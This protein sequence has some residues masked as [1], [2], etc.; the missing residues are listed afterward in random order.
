PASSMSAVAVQ[1]PLTGL[2]S[3][4]VAS[5]PKPPLPPPAMSTLPSGSSVAVWPIRASIIPPVGYHPGALA[6]TTD[7]LGTGAAVELGADSVA[8]NPDAGGVSEEPGPG[9]GRARIDPKRPAPIATTSAP[10]PTSNSR[11]F[12]VMFGFLHGA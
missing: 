11:V 3:S 6:A 4:A 10:P 8:E 1:V 2:Y 12:R 5:E 9:L 7:E